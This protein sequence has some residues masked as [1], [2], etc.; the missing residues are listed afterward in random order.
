MPVLP[1]RA[2]VSDVGNDILYGVPEDQ[3]LEW[4]EEAL[5]R[6]QRITKDIIVTTLPLDNIR[7]LS[8]AKFVSFRSI[9]FPHSRLSHSQVL[10]AAERVDAGLAQ[11]SANCN[12]RL[13][14]LDP[15]WYGLD[16]IHIRRSLWLSAWREILDLRSPVGRY[17]SSFLEGLKLF[18]MPPE[19]RWLFGVEQFT[20]QNGRA[21]P[22][23]GRIWLY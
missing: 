2:V 15:E 11:L 7:G 18:L 4:I 19:R 20:P 13:F 23:G 1:T 6:L 21:L 10:A 17:G 8:P 12:L 5:R 14:R 16:P 3:I 9:L 22:S